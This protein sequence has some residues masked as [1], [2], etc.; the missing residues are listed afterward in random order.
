MITY[1]EVEAAVR[2][3]LGDMMTVAEIVA[4]PKVEGAW[5]VRAWFS[6][7]DG[8]GEEKVDFIV[9]SSADMLPRHRPSDILEETRFDGWPP[10]SGV[11][12]IERTAWR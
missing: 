10:A 9:K 8:E 3:C 7:P 2:D 4:D 1:D 6:G 12:S 11:V 5:A